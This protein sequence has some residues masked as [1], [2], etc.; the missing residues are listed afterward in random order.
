MI[1]SFHALIFQK[2]MNEM[3]D[4]HWYN[5]QIS[6]SVHITYRVNVE[7]DATNPQ[8]FWVLTEVHYYINDDKTHDRLFVKHAFILHWGYMKNKGCF[9]KQHLVWSDG[10]STQFKCVK[11][12]V[13]YYLWPKTK[14]C[15]NVL[16]FTI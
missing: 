10:Y 4:M 11:S 12:M 7:Y 15:P 1:W 3:Q 9:P 13:L 2:T 16:E 5:M 14:R 6:I 8:S